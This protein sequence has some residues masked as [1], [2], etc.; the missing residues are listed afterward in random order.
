MSNKK[1]AS[2]ISSNQEIRGVEID[3]KNIQPRVNE[4]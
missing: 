2:I 4:R 3:K 1:G